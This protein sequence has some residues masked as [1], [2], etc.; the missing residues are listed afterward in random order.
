[1]SRYRLLMVAG[2][3]VA[4]VRVGLLFFGNL[5]RNLVYFLTPAEAV[6]QRAEW[7]DGRRLQIGGLVDPGSVVRTPDGLGF[8]LAAEAGPGGV[9][10]PVRHTGAPAQLFRSGIGVVLEGVWRDEQFVSDT[11]IV[12]HDENYRPP[13]ESSQ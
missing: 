4:A 11:M 10:I 9:T 3:G 7:P 13:E 5:N 8:M 12:K 6:A 2:A 1:M